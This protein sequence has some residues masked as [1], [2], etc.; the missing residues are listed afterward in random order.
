[1]ASLRREV[2]KALRLEKACPKCGSHLMVREGENGDFL[3]CP[4][5]PACRFTKPLTENYFKDNVLQGIYHKPSLY[6][7]KCNHTGLLPFIKK[8]NSIPYAFIDCECKLNIPEHLD[9]ARIQPEDFDFP[10]SDTFRGFSYEYCGQPDPSYTPIAQGNDT[11]T[12]K[13][14]R[15]EEPQ[16]VERWSKNQWHKVLSMEEEIERLRRTAYRYLK[17][18]RELTASASKR[19]PETNTTKLNNIYKG[20]ESGNEQSR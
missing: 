2:K 9:P 3:A 20:I 11:H 8:G 6:C 13:S 4:K 5:F 15:P 14:E 18:M 17:E 12:Q 7:E 1:M 16:I 10:M 19:R